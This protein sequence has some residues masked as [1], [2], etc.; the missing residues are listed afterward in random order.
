MNI[1]FE[2]DLTVE[3]AADIKQQ[4]LDALST[5]ESVE[6]GFSKAADADLTFFQLLHA[7]KKSFAARQQPLILKKDLPEHL[8]FKAQV[9]GMEE[10]IVV[11]VD[12]NSSR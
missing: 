10:I 1:E 3:R 4:L 11:G 9:S 6:L 2:G 7:A 5:G 8:A 12:A